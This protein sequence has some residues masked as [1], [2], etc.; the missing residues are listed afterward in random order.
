MREADA[1]RLTEADAERQ[2]SDVVIKNL[3]LFS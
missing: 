2:T 3:T 1:Q